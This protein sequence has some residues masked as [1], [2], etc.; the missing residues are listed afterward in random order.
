MNGIHGSQVPKWLK[1]AGPEADQLWA[2]LGGVDKILLPEFFKRRRP[3]A[4]V[5]HLERYYRGERENTL[6]C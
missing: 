4:M 6:I 5:S 3:Y 2:A 1:T